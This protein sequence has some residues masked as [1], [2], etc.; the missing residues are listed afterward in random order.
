MI[1]SDFYK[2]KNLSLFD[3][4]EKMKINVFDWE[5]PEGFP[6][7]MEPREIQRDWQTYLATWPTYGSRISE[8]IVRYGNALEHP[9]IL[10]LKSRQIIADALAEKTKQEKYRVLACNVLAD[11]VHCV[12]VCTKDQL[13]DIIHDLKGYSSFTHNRLLKLSV[14]GM[15]VVGK[16][17]QTKLWAKG[18]HKQELKT[19]KHTRNAIDYVW[20]NHHKHDVEAID[21]RQ[22][23]QSVVSLDTAYEPDQEPGGF[24]VVIGNPPY[25][26][27][28]TL[29]DTF[30]QYTQAKYKTYA[31]TADL[32]VYFIEQGLNLLRPKG[33][34]SIIVSN[35]WMR[36]NYGRALRDFLKKK[37]VYELIDF[38]DLPVFQGATTYPCIL[39]LSNAQPENFKALKVKSLGSETNQ[40]WLAQ[41]FKANSYQVNLQYLYNDVW[42]LH[43][44]AEA[45]LLEK[46]KNSGIPLEEY[47]QGKIYYGIKTGLNEAFVIDEATKDRLIREDSKSSE[48]IKPLLEGKDIKRYGVLENRKWLI[49]T[50]RGIDIRKYSAILNYLEKY[51]E[52][53]KPK[54]KNWPFNKSWLGR[55]PGAYQWYEIQDSID[56]YQEFEEPKI[57]WGNLAKVS[58]FTFD[59]KGIYINAPSCILNTESLYVLGCLNSKVNWWFLK[60]ITAERQGGYIEAKPIYVEQISIPKASD[61]QENQMVSFVDQMLA[62]Q[63]KLYETSSPIEKKQYQQ[64]ADILDK[65]IDQLVYK[66][67]ELTPEEIRIVEGGT[68]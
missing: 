24:D 25:V 30:K 39:R 28:E 6:E 23:K 55:K 44:E 66:L 52:K 16:G 19:A 59:S 22:L 54:P 40:N 31:G 21:N 53:L 5:S 36:T 32:Y 37:K 9:V 43:T 11:H 34:Y 65:Q 56:Y 29:G 2:G 49:F 18:S 17:K 20:N 41:A 4:D 47:V 38:G 58:P 63:K 45:T 7:I 48:I 68:R 1:G 35:K 62:V 64:E 51:K 42:S 61:L 27:Q 8:E 12:L 50:R 14:V 46:V 15:S 3:R 13:S 33:L 26:R 67:Y 60:S 57:T 10:S